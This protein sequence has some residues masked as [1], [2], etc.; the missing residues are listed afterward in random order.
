MKKRNVVSLSQMAALSGYDRKT[1]A[2]MIEIEG[3]PVVSRGHQGKA[4]QVD[5]VDFF[6]WLRER[7]LI[8]DADE[9]K[10]ARLGKLRE[11]RR[12]LQLE[13]DERLAGLVPA[14][15]AAELCHATVAIL[16]SSLGPA[17][18]R[19]AGKDAVLRQKIEGEFGRILN[20][21]RA[22]LSRYDSAE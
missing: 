4:A 19:I 16:E 6:E 9:M 10:L 22:R 7:A 12:A 1:I 14:E 13:N 18:A 2:R 11:E 5:T 8:T 15:D 20:T 3:A 21:T 17:A